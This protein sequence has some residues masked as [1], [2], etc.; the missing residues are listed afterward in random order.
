MVEVLVTWGLCLMG[1]LSWGP[2]FRF[3]GFGLQVIKLQGQGVLY[4]SAL[5]VKGLIMVM[6]VI[7]GFEMM[8][9]YN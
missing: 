1:F 5:W 4:T 8:Q 9:H 3:W 2:R 6:I 7:C